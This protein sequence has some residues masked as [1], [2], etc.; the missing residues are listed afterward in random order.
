[1]TSRVSGYE[2]VARV[3]LPCGHT[4]ADH[5]KATA[6]IAR[7]AEDLIENGFAELDISNRWAPKHKVEPVMEHVPG[8]S[9]G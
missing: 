3:F 5:A 1:M 8:A 7:L 9:N 6:T 4:A 2:I